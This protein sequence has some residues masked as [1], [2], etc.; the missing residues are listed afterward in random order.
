MKSIHIKMFALVD[1]IERVDS[2]QFLD[3]IQ[4]DDSIQ[5]DDLINGRRSTMGIRQRYL[6]V[7]RPLQ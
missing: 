4:F 6:V 2:I 1:S 5:F 3:P 7:A